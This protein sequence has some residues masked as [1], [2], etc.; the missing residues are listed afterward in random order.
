VIEPLRLKAEDVAMDRARQA[1]R[2]ASASLPHLSGLSRFIRV[3]PTRRVSVAAVA[4]SG[5]VLVQP[6]IFSTIPVGEAA[7]VLAHELM[8]LALDTHGRQGE[9]DHLLV[10]YAH[11]YIIN[12]MLRDELG[13][14]PPLHGLDMPGAREKSLEELCTELSEGAGPDQCWDPKGASRRTRNRQQSPGAMRRALEDAGLVEKESE[15]QRVRPDPQLSPGDLLPEDREPEFEPEISPELRKRFKEEVRKAAAKAASLAELKKKMDEAGQPAD[16]SEPQRGSATMRALRDAYAPPWELALQ[17]WMDAV[18][19]GERTYARPSRRGASASD[20]VRP[21]R[22]RT[23]WT[24]HII[25]DTSG[26][27]VDFL[28]RALGA[29]A[30]FCDASGVDEVRLVQCDVEVTS[31]RWVEPQELA[32]YKITGFGYSDMTPG[33]MHLAEDPEVEAA[34]L[35]TDGYI[36]IPAEPPPYRLVFG[37]IGQINRSFN[38]PYGQIIQLPSLQQA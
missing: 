14:D 11:D 8:H 12:D 34:I 21:G 22:R 24:L 32:E 18:S 35:L 31:D 23:G 38:P 4:P 37:L 27:M 5:L 17:R 20:A 28:P 30:T 29:I 13:R 1:L 33:I 9:T 16:L 10:N 2:L 6:D 7:Y 26:S 25:L 3:K 15:P 36:E 19:P